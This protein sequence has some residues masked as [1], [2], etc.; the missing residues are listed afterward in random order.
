MPESEPASFDRGSEVDAMKK[1]LSTLLL[2]ICL[3]GCVTT[4]A[5]LT[6][7][8][9]AV[10][11]EETG[12]CHID[13]AMWVDGKILEGIGVIDPDADPAWRGLVSVEGVVTSGGTPVQQARTELFRRSGQ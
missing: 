1:L 7:A 13:D 5:V 2:T 6:C 3:S 4:A 11:G 8:A 12:D 10:F 9:G